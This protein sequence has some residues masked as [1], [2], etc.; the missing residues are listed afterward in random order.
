MHARQCSI[1]YGPNS[2]ARTYPDCIAERL[3]AAYPQV[4]A[5]DAALSGRAH[6]RR[7]PGACGTLMTANGHKLSFVRD[8][9]AIYEAARLALAAGL[10]LA[11]RKG[12]TIH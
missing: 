3:I 8:S 1:R 7:W 10:R 4:S 6:I 9:N 5:Y 12:L 11:S 2:R